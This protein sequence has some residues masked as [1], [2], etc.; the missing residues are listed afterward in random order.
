MRVCGGPLDEHDLDRGTCHDCRSPKGKIADLDIAIRASGDD[1]KRI[2][3]WP[4]IRHLLRKRFGENRSDAELWERCTD[5]LRAEGRLTP[6]DYLPLP[7]NYLQWLL[8]HGFSRTEQAGNEKLAALQAFQR[9]LESWNCS[10]SPSET[11]YV[12]EDVPI[13]HPLH[14][15]VVALQPFYGGA[16]PK[17]AP[18]HSRMFLKLARNDDEAAEGKAEL[19]LQWVNGEIESHRADEQPSG[20][21]STEPRVKAGDAFLRATEND[22]DA[23]AALHRTRA[24]MQAFAEAMQEAM[25]SP[26]YRAAQEV[27]RQQWQELADA[28]LAAV[29]TAG[30]ELELRHFARPETIEDWEHLARIVEIPAETIKTGNLTAR[31]IFACALAWVDRQKIKAKLAADTNGEVSQ[32]EPAEATS[33]T[34][35]PTKAKRSTEKGEG[36][37]KLIAALT[38]HHKYA[39]GSCLNLEPVGNN[40]LARLA[41]VSESTASAFFNK[42]FG[43]HTKYRAICSDATRLIAALKLLN[44]E[45]SPHHLFGAKPPGEDEREDEE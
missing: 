42:Q 20:G 25:D 37:A 9:E 33:K 18:G 39:D 26:D 5:W 6:N 23:K 45:F 4:V 43:G 2:S 1:P 24:R 32:A 34:T 14:A 12:V 11:G 31:E 16:L 21:D 29:K 22:P 17:P 10:N 30:D 44:Q 35:T 15:A 7:L 3:D 13:G 40:E 36:Q 41:E 38:K 27:E 19:L 28:I 8:E